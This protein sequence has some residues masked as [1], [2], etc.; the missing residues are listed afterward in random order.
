MNIKID[1]SRLIKIRKIRKLT[2]ADMAS[3]LGISLRTYSDYENLSSEALLSHMETHKLSRVLGVAVSDLWAFIPHSVTLFYGAVCNYS[4]WAK[5]LAAG[6]FEDLAISGLPND[7]RLR[8]PLLKLVG[9]YEARKKE[10]KEGGQTEKLSSSIQRSFDCEDWLQEL[11]GGENFFETVEA[12]NSASDLSPDILVMKVPK[13][14]VCYDE[15]P[16]PDETSNEAIG[17]YSYFWDIKWHAKIDFT[18]AAPLTNP[19]R[20][21]YL[22]G[23]ADALF[24]NQDFVS[25]EDL[26]EHEE[27]DFWKATKETETRI[28]AALES[29]SVKFDNEIFG[30]QN[31]E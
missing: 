24:C 29:R 5:L 31:V 30:R 14:H 20:L 27:K 1:R 25:P 9:V 7:K 12:Q 4:Q 28:K 6:M 10:G 19:R 15:Y 26:T 8:E 18:N 23:A 22:S 11:V 21:E 3:M 2:Q 17:Q 13:L 16:H